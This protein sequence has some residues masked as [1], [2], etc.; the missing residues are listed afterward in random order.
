M[1]KKICGLMVVLAVITFADA[2]HAENNEQKQTD[3]E[4]PVSARSQRPVLELRS[5]AQPPLIDGRLDEPA[6]RDAPAITNFT[7][8]LPVEGTPPTE[9]TE[10]R[11]LYT[12]D[13]LYIAVRCFD[14]EPGRIIAKQM[15]H[16]GTLKSDDMV[17]IAFDT[18]HRQRDGYFFS[19]NPAGVRV[20]GLIEDFETQSLLWDAIWR[21][22]A[23]V[24]ELGWTA[25]V[26]IPFKSLS[27]DS[28][29]DTWGCN[30][31][32]VIRRKQETIRWAGLSRAKTVTQLSDFGEL[33]GLTNLRQG[34]GLELKP[35]VSAEYLDDAT[36]DKR[37]WD[38]N[39]GGDILYRITPSLTAQATFN[40]DFAEAEVDKR[41]VNL[42]RFPLFFPE[43][44][45]FF[46]QDAS[47]F[48]FG[49]LS[50]SFLPYYSRRIGMGND[51]QPVDIL[52]GGRM[53]GR[54]GGTRIALLNVLQDDHGGIS[55]KNLAVARVSQQVLEESNVG[56]IV[57]SGDP[58][59]DGDTTLI[60]ADFNYLNSRLPDERQL[61]G[62]AFLMGSFSDRMDGND[63]SFG[64]DIDYP[65]EPLDVHLF[66]RQIGEKFDPAMGFV[67]R[68][69]IRDYEGSARYIWRPNGSLIR[70]VRLSGRPFFTTDL[71]D[72]LVAE[73]HNVPVLMLTT[74]AGDS[75]TLMYTWY[76]DVVDETFEMWPGVD[77]PP[78]DYGYGQFK[79]SLTT[80]EARPVSAKFK[81]RVGDFYDG[82]IASYYGSLDWRPSRHLTTGVA[83]ELRDIDLSQGHFYVR[84]ASAKLDIAFTP[85]LS[86]NTI[87]QYDN[88][89]S[90]LG[91]NSRFRWTFRPGNDV[92]LVFNQGYDYDNWR[93]DRLHSEVTMKVGATMR[94]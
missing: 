30:I 42:T 49:G 10:V 92:F 37:E 23:R 44:R 70:T 11:F 1:L 51:G 79:P 61:V 16:D 32:R 54:V 48:S 94:F 7:Q 22:R 18:F 14:S 47:L 40:T 45:D 93:F 57:T 52:A 50:K 6:W 39:S 66:F 82:D 59:H 19:V 34:L 83:Y 3:T 77:I 26:E 35:F 38:L 89:S 4:N 55:Q 15:Q 58:L 21:V 5:I 85:D 28:S 8:V 24:D 31:E 76:R 43:K 56:L 53:T 41:Q 60:G 74:P 25:E 2:L 81:Y 69:G 27:F 29:S 65:N 80:S 12:R 88:R 84:V 17:T 87:A 90:Q 62:N 68:R 20:E 36:A 9:R 67:G 13:A 64:G 75:L 33:R 86:W 63:L 73:D 91:F 78:G 71:D 72:R 46:L